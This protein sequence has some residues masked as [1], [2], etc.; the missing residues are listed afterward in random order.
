MGI[1]DILS[2]SHDMALMGDRP[3]DNNFELLPFLG[4]L[5]PFP[6]TPFRLAKTYKVQLSFVLGFKEDGQ[7]YGLAARTLD[8]RSLSVQEAMMEYIQFVEKTIGKHPK[9]WF[10]HYN[11]FSRRPT[12]PDG[13]LCLPHRYRM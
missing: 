1:H 10:N 11:F 6:S 8:M 3:F 12:R 7:N 9:Q 13:S 5:A 2:N 4:K